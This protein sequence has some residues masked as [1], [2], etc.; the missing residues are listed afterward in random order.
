MRKKLTKVSQ[1]VRD[2]EQ[3]PAGDFTLHS[4]IGGGY[5]L[6][7][8]GDVDELMDRLGKY[9][10]AD[11][12]L[13]TDLALKAIRVFT[14]TVKSCQFLTES[15]AY[16]ELNLGASAGFGARGFGVRDRKDPL[17]QDY[18]REYL[19]VAKQWIVNVII[20]ASQK[21]EMRAFEH[22][23]KTGENKL[24]TPRL[25]MSY[26]V[27]AT[28]LSTIVLG[29]FLR[30]LYENS[31]MKNGFPSAVGD[32]IQDGAL[33][34]YKIMLSKRP[35]LYCTDT[36]GQ[37]AS[38]PAEFLRLVYQC[39]REKYI[40]DE[41]DRSWF[42]NVEH[43]SINK[44]LNVNGYLYECPRGLASGD[45]LTIVINM[46]WRLY[47][48]YASYNHDISTYHQENTVIVCG[49]DWIQSSDHADLDLNS[50]Y[51]TI[52]W[53]GQPVTW[54]EMDFCSCRFD[55]YIHHDPVKV[56]SVLKGRRLAATAG[57][58]SAEMQ[59]LAGLLRVCSTEEVHQIITQKMA[60]LR[61]KYNLTSEYDSAWVPWQVVF[62][63]YNTF[64]TFH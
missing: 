52:T 18:L 12:P 16:G 3:P 41:E 55:P 64:A 5:A 39:I 57:S 51:A 61:D 42:D 36:S 43:N 6:A 11:K 62:D 53:A 7:E 34:Y 48:A 31:F 23:K 17:L 33:A 26:P 19:E 15:A 45:Y 2:L 44:V 56:L 38:V 46:M 30:Q 59:R 60:N 50:E 9:D 27:E 25:F 40:L 63:N 22:D 21:D 13:N 29:D 32:S 24:K 49:D 58:P 35:H 28:F 14:D 10:L 47:I 8:L 20:T 37:D 1:Y 4:Q 54:A